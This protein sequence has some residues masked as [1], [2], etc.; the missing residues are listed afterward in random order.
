M[1]A[2]RGGERG[3]STRMEF[4]VGWTRAACGRRTTKGSERRHVSG[5]H[6]RRRVEGYGSGE[7][8]EP[9]ASRG[10]SSA[11][12]TGLKGDTRAKPRSNGDVT[13][14]LDPTVYGLMGDVDIVP[15]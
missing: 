1:Q 2:A 10:F 14:L 8:K 4:G 5:R 15:S 9:V 12:V 6:S 7:A 13:C 11:W 3:R